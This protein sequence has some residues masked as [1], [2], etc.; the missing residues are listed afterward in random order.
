MGSSFFCGYGFDCTAGGRLD[1]AFAVRDFSLAAGVFPPVKA[2]AIVFDFP[3]SACAAPVSFFYT[4]GGAP[5]SA[6]F[7]LHSNFSIF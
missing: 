4:G 7:E 6:V 5:G 3:A 2:L 1:F